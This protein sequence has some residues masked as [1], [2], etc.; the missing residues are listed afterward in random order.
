MHYFSVQRR[1]KMEGHQIKIP[2][3]MIQD[4]LI[5]NFFKKVRLDSSVTFG[6]CN[7]CSELIFFCPGKKILHEHLKLH[8]NIWNL[9]LSEVG[10]ATVPFVPA[11]TG[12][13]VLKL[14][15]FHIDNNT[16]EEFSL[17]FPASRIQ[18]DFSK[19]DITEALSGFEGR[20]QKE[21]NMSTVGPY[22]G[23]YDQH[24]ALRLSD[25]LSDSDLNYDQYTEFEHPNDFSCCV[26]SIKDSYKQ[27]EP[28]KKID[29]LQID[30]DLDQSFDFDEEQVLYTCQ[31]KTCRI[32]CPCSPCCTREN[33]CREH[34]IKHED[35]FDGK[36]DVVL[37]RSSDEFCTDQSFIS[38]SY[39]VK[40]PGIPFKCLQCK[41]MFAF[42]TI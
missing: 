17:R 23:P 7:T 34:T 10:D 42:A 21:Y 28:L 25:Q 14:T 13:D 15:T 19:L 30:K 39:N 37:V 22:M 32:P 40:Y 8:P 2:L 26:F 1:F 5:M 4:N 9:Y 27:V 38:R 41:I 36:V 12:V 6:K 16:K 3:S 31:K 29:S 20:I 11:Q 35:Q 24:E 33:Q 18:R